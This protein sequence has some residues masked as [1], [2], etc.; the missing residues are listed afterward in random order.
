[1]KNPYNHTLSHQKPLFSLCFIINFSM[2]V[3]ACDDPTP[4]MSKPDQSL[5]SELDMKVTEPDLSIEVDQELEDMLIEEVDAGPNEIAWIELKLSPVRSVYN[6]GDIVRLTI[7][8]YD[9]YGDLDLDQDLQVEFESPLGTFHTVDSELEVGVIS[10]ERQLD[11][12][13][14][15]EGSSVIKVCSIG[16]DSLE[17]TGVCAQRPILVDDSGPDIEVFWPPRGAMLSANDVWPNWEGLMLDVPEPAPTYHGLLENPDADLSRYVPVYGKV[18]GLGPGRL[19]LNDKPIEVSENGY[20]ST[21]VPQRSGFIELN[22]VADDEIRLSPSHNRRWVLFAADYIEHQDNLS[23]IP[24]GIDLAVHQSFVDQDQDSVSSEPYQVTEIAQLIDLFLSLI[25][26]GR[27]LAQSNLITSP[28][29]SLSVTNIDL[30]SPNIDL[31]I[32]DDG[33]ALFCNLNQVLIE[34]DG[35]LNVGSSVIDLSGQLS[36]SLSAYADYQLGTG[37]QTLTVNYLGGGVAV[38][39]INPQLNESAANAVISVLDSRARTLIVEQLETQLNLLFQ[40]DIPIL[41]E[42][43]VDDI[44]RTIDQIPLELNSG[45]EESSTADLLIEITPRSVSSNT[46]EQVLLSADVT[47]KNRSETIAHEESRGTPRLTLNPRRFVDNSPVSFT[48][49]P[50]FINALLVE[51]WRSQLLDLKPPLPASAALFFSEVQAYALCPPILTIGE[52]FEPYPLYLELGALRL[53][54]TQ[55]SS[56]LDDV[57]EIFIRVGAS[58]QV[59]GGTFT[60]QLEDQPQV[61]VTLSSLGNE[62]PAVTEQ[63]IS[64]LFSEQIWPELSTALVSRLV[65]GIPDSQFSLNELAYLGINLAEAWVRPQFDQRIRYAPNGIILG[66]ELLFDF[67]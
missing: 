54:M 34:V 66:G 47:I 16:D 17:P 4:P 6:S 64:N 43:T 51:I 23:P 24:L 50:E 14:T 28:E 49:Q 55:S 59:D 2:L 52:S 9:V 5:I 53:N 40:R 35:S 3:S 26:T 62:R 20:F 25:D 30:A 56:G 65:L 41:L 67:P 57:Y 29:L 12:H 13:F 21:I 22:L 38:T 32:T 33:L 39:Q 18:T 46:Q 15:Q 11:L 63:L 60:I 36:L 37:Q 58:L 10:N 45:F 31:Q 19:S 7:E 48:I 44:Y 61:E 27:L 42:T 8:A 1:M